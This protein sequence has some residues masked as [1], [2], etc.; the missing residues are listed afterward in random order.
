LSDLE[1]WAKSVRAGDRAAFDAIVRATERSMFR[2]AARLLGDYDEAGDVLQDAYVRAF[3]ALTSGEFDGRARVST[4][5][6][7]VVTNAS[8]D[9]LRARK[10]RRTVPI[11]EAA[12]HGNEG[13]AEARLALRE[14]GTLLDDLPDEQRVAIVLKELEGLSSAEVAKVVGV[15]E[16]AVE[17]RLVRARVTLR[18]KVGDA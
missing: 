9:A 18:A 11:E 3:E 6:Y 16:G 10:R 14:L 5:L 4:W 1:A 12:E 2:V 15:S 13:A 7:R 17:Q 8:L